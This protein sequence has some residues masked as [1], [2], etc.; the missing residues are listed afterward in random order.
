M[1]TL[2]GSRD[3]SNA[4]ARSYSETVQMPTLSLGGRVVIIKE[5][6]LRSNRSESKMKYYIYIYIYIY[7]RQQTKTKKKRY[8]YIKVTQHK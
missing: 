4:Y 2:T 5:R 7:K 1:S 3:S 6:G 8:I